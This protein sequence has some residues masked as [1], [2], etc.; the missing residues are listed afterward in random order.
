[1]SATKKPGYYPGPQAGDFIQAEEPFALF[2]SWYSEAQQHEPNDPEAMALATVDGSGLPNLRMV[3]LKGVDPPEH[4]DRGFLFFTNFESAKGVELLASRKAALLLHWK[5]LRR[6]VRVR[7]SVTEVSAAEADA[8]FVTRPRGSRIGA[9]A[10]RQSRPME[11]P[12]ALKKA[13]AVY[14]A[15]FGLGAIPRPPYWSGFRVTPLEMEF[16]HD[17]PFRLHDRIAFRRSSAGEP[18]V[19]SRLYP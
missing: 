1:M 14:A 9:W 19:R 11:G 16:W 12:F 15:K 7:G 17:R 10:S 5:S 8:Y 3:L 2:E 18:W 13:V 4:A 6:Q